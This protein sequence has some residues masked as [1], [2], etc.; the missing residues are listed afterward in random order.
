[1]NVKNLTEDLTLED[2]LIILGGLNGYYDRIKPSVQS[3]INKLKMCTNTN[4][5][6]GKIPLPNTTGKELKNSIDNFNCGMHCNLKKI[7]YYCENKM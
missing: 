5:L 1:M 7:N 4:V 3:V 2:Y 6:M